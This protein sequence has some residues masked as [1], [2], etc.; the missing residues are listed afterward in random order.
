MFIVGQLKKFID[1][2]GPEAN[3]EK[4]RRLTSELGGDK[5]KQMSHIAEDILGEHAKEFFQ[6]ITEDPEYMQL[7]IA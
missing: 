3:P 1:T 4:M 2:L 5:D 7:A 6:R